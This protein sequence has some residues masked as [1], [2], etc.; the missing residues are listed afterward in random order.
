[1]FI[2]LHHDC[3]RNSAHIFSFGCKW[4]FERFRVAT[5]KAFRLVFLLYMHSQPVCNGGWCFHDSTYEETTFRSELSNADMDSFYCDY[6][7]LFCKRVT[8]N[9]KVTKYI[10]TLK[11]SFQKCCYNSKCNTKVSEFWNVCTFNSQLAKSK[12]VCVH[13]AFTK[14]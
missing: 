4:S 8:M 10:T 13:S 6:S 9:V 5:L 12:R 11:N 14:I 3:L 7:Q 1:M 2:P